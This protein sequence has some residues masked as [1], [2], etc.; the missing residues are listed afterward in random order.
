MKFFLPI[1]TLLALGLCL[2]GCSVFGNSGVEIA[3]Y[4]VVLKEGDVEIRNY[5]KLILVTTPMPQGMKE[6]QNEA[7]SR[8]FD[9]ITGTNVAADKI[10]M[11]APVIMDQGDKEEGQKIEMTAPVFMGENGK[12]ETMSFVLPDS[13]TMESAPQPTD[14]QVK[15]QEIKNYTVAVLRFSGFLNEDSSMAQKK[16]LEDWIAKSAY[17]STGDYKVAGYN[18]PWTLPFMRRNEVLIPVTKK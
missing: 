17:K 3:P 9:Y 16:I 7:F 15:L 2:G 8:L 18:P 4:S 14:P 6:S 11:T 12:M 10:A 13:F 1:L 5:E